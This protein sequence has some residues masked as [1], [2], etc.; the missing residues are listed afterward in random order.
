MSSLQYIAEFG[1]ELRKHGSWLY[2]E[3][4]FD[5]IYFQDSRFNL[6]TFFDPLSD[7]FINMS[8]ERRQL[9]L[10]E[11]FYCGIIGIKLDLLYHRFCIDTNKEDLYAIFNRVL[12]KILEESFAI[13]P[14]E[15]DIHNPNNWYFG[16]ADNPPKITSHEAIIRGLERMDKEAFDYFKIQNDLL[17][18]KRLTYSQNLDFLIASNPDSKLDQLDEELLKRA[19]LLPSDMKERYGEV[20]LLVEDIL[21]DFEPERKEKRIKLAETIYKAVEELDL[22]T[23]KELDIYKNK[24]IEHFVDIKTKPKEWLYNQIHYLPLKRELCKLRGIEFY[25]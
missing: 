25:K 16:K 15:I 19:D 22:E 1:E 23:L 2:D 4:D 5:Y 11:L 21:D 8:S 7:D 9:I 3:K 17:L 12:N 13:N 14:F 10:K 20:G 18:R 6:Q 24:R